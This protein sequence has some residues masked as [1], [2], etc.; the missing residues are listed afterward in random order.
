MGYVFIDEEKIKKIFSRNKERE[1]K[2]KYELVVIVQNVGRKFIIIIILSLVLTVIC[3]VYISC[4]NNVYPNIKDEWI[5]SSIFILILMQIINFVFTFMECILRYTAIKCN[6]E[7]M[8]KLSQVF[9][10]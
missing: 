4:F 7:K 10:L 9:A 8:F 3:F 6:N 1:L 2:L 5:K